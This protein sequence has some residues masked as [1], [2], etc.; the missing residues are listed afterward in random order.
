MRNE[1]D[2]AVG[3]AR[4]NLQDRCFG[5]VRC[6]GYAKSANWPKFTLSQTSLVVGLTVV[7]QPKIGFLHVCRLNKRILTAV[8][9]RIIS[10]SVFGF[11]S[12]N[13]SKVVKLHSRPR[14]RGHAGRCRRC[15]PPTLVL[16]RSEPPVLH[17]AL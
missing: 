2:D 1:A 4:W 16:Q 10:W 14:M 8:K 6:N 7:R 12:A 5:N 13:K 9:S 11:A 17:L 3:K 15:F